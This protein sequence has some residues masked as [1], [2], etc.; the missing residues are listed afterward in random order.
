MT[1]ISDIGKS[2]EG[3]GLTIETYKQVEDSY[4]KAIQLV[5]DYL[6]VPYLL[7]NNVI[8]SFSYQ[9]FLENTKEFDELYPN[10]LMEVYTNTWDIEKIDKEKVVLFCR[11]LFREDI[12]SDVYFPRK[13]KVFI[14][15]D[16]LMGV[17]TS[18]SI[19]SI[20]PAI[21]QLGLFVVEH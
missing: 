14:G 21:E 16:Y 18:K 1:A 12:G 5:M 15:Y 10:D 3:E 4:I 8:R 17:H 11:L 19:D 6:G 20:R 7:V 9:K 2:F 13:L